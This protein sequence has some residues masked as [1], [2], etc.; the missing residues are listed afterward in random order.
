MIRFAPATA[1]TRAIARDIAPSKT[2]AEI[3]A[4]IPIEATD[5]SERVVESGMLLT[6]LPAAPSKTTKA[7]SPK[8]PRAKPETTTAQLDLNT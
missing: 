8:K 2:T 3:L 7:R 6:E 1:P 4:V 5:A